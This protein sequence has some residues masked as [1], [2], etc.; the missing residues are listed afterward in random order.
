MPRSSPG[1]SSRPNARRPKAGHS[2]RRTPTGARPMTA[3]QARRAR[4]ATDRHRM[5]GLGMVLLILVLGAMALG[6]YAD[7]TAA[8][9]RVQTLVAERTALD[10]AVA[11][12]ESEAARLEDP[13]ALEEPARE[14]LGLARPGEIP[15][16]VVNPPTEQPAALN[17]LPEGED[18]LPA[19]SRLDQL[20]DWVRDLKF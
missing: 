15:Y 9:D 12:L 2:R 4:R 5:Y 19:P 18:H 13:A 20:I 3:A 10:D 16:I 17:V 6:P 8:Q 14:D 1:L 7:Y 11:E